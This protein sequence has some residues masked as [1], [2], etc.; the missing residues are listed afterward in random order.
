MSSG[1]PDAQA[2][3]NAKISQVSQEQVPHSPVGSPIHNKFLVPSPVPTRRNRTYSQTERAK[4]AEICYGKV[5]EFC[6]NK[7]HGF[8]IEDNTNDKIFVH[9]SD[10]DGEYVPREGDDV[11]FRKLPLPFNKTKTQAVHV[12]ITHLAPGVSH[13]TWSSNQSP[14]P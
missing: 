12:A 13:E 1:L 9:I 2:V 3:N 6:R 10:I 4:D 8:I 7:G 11:T 5:Q 14:R